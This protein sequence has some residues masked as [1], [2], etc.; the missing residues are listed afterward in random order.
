MEVVVSNIGKFAVAPCLCHSLG[1][2][3]IVSP[4][5]TR[6]RVSS[7]IPSQKLVSQNQWA[8]RVSIRAP[9]D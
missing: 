7:F 4:A 1:P 5:C 8:A 9:W 2:I 3:Q 6:W